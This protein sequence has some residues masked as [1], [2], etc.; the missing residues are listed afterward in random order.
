MIELAVGE[1]ITIGNVG[2]LLWIRYRW[3]FVRKTFQLLAFSN[4]QV[5]LLDV[6][7]TK[8]ELKRGEGK[9]EKRGKEEKNSTS[10]DN[11]RSGFTWIRMRLSLFSQVL[12]IGLEIIT[13]RVVTSIGHV[14]RRERCYSR[15]AVQRAMHFSH[16][17]LSS[18]TVVNFNT[19]RR[20]PWI[21]ILGCNV[22]PHRAALV[23]RSADRLSALP[24]FRYLFFVT[25]FSLHPFSSGELPLDSIP[26]SFD[27]PRNSFGRVTRVKMIDSACGMPA[28]IGST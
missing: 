4:L 10:I 18:E 27:L 23:T 5:D 14:R 20:S 6:R 2:E 3:P 7:V 26:L 17:R 22:M 16:P 12:L 24:L 15:H 25:S 9:S 13:R 1:P 19:P 11:S 8:I 28:L 21:R